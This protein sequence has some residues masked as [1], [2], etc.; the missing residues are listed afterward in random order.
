M[1]KNGARA[2]CLPFARSHT[3]ISDIV[4]LVMIS[5]ITRRF[6]PKISWKKVYRFEKSVSFS[7]I[8]RKYSVHKQS[9]SEVVSF[10]DLRLQ[11]H[12]KFLS[13]LYTNSGGNTSDLK[14]NI[15]ISYQALSHIHSL[16][17]EIEKTK[18]EIK[19]VDFL[20]SGNFL[21]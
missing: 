9:L 17:S 10:D 18:E 2:V 7:V 11:K 13:D 15:G 21:I 1:S 14:Q 19:E 20:I 12:L 3:K 16:T 8:N 6:L 5:F 4:I